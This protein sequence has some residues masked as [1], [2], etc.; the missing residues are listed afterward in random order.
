MARRDPYSNARF[1]L[2]LGNI[3]QASFSE[4]TGFD[5]STDPIEY[6]E[7]NDKE[8]TV[9]KQPGLTKYGNI[10]L[11]WGLSDS[12]EIWEWRKDV[13]DGKMEKARINGSIV[14]KN[15]EGDDKVQWD[16]VAGWPSKYD[17]ADLNAKGNDIAIESLE[18]THEGI[19]RTK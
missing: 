19:K 8:G 9:R 5:I 2:R 1:E 7:G 3:K 13:I 14:V 17:P 6:R 10:T 16:F 18:I 11:K 12:T 15:E 4:C